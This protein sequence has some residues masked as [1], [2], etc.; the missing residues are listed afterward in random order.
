M[1]NKFEAAYILGQK[2]AMEKVA[3]DRGG[4][5]YNP[6]Y[7]QS[8][9][10]AIRRYNRDVASGRSNHTAL[11]AALAGGG[12]GLIRGGMRGGLIGAGLGLVAGKGIGYLGSRLGQGFD[13]YLYTDVNSQDRR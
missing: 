4:L 10:D 12:L 1:N 13:N 11:G 5:T 2:A 7:S 9:I 8:D 6:T 3:Q